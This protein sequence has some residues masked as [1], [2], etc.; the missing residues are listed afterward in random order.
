MS[1]LIFKYPLDFTGQN[2]TNRIFEEIHSLQGSGNRA[3]IPKFGAFYTASLI[4]TDTVS[5]KQL[6]A[7]DQYVPILYWDEPSEKSGLEVCAGV[8]ITD[9]TVSNSVVITYQCVGGLYANITGI[10]S[11]LINTLDIDNRPVSWGDLLDVPNAF[12]PVAHLHALGDIYGFEYIVDKLEGIRHAI[13]T[14]DEASHVEILAYINQRADAM[15]QAV[16]HV[17]ET[18]GGHVQD[19]DNPH[20]T[21]KGH[22]GL[23][24]V[25]NFPTA[26]VEIA[27]LGESNAHF[28]TPLLV[29]QAIDALTNYSDWDVVAGDWGYMRHRTSGLTVQWGSTGPLKHGEAG[30]C[31]FRVPFD[32]RPWTVVPGNLTVS[33][34][35]SNISTQDNDVFNE[36]YCSVVN[37]SITAE[38]LIMAARRLGGTQ[39]DWTVGTWMAVGITTDP[40]L[41]PDS[42]RYMFLGTDNIGLGGDI[43]ITNVGGFAIDPNTWTIDLFSQDDTVFE[44]T[45]NG[46]EAIRGTVV[47]FVVSVA[48]GTAQ[49]PIVASN[50]A[51]LIAVSPIPGQFAY[52]VMFTMPGNDVEI[53]IGDAR[54]RYPWS[55]ELYE[56]DDTTFEVIPMSGE[57]PHGSTVTFR[58]NT[59]FGT[60]REPN[61]QSSNATNIVV[62]EVGDGVLAH[63]VSFTMPSAPTTIIV[64]D[65]PAPAFTLNRPTLTLSNI[66]EDRLSWLVGNIA[67]TNPIQTYQVQLHRTNSS[68]TIIYET[69]T[70]TDTNIGQWLNLNNNTTYYF[71][72]VFT[73]TDIYGQT[74]TSQE[75]I[76]RQAT[77]A[78]PTPPATLFLEEFDI[79]NVTGYLIKV[80]S[81]MAPPNTYRIVLH[82]A[83]YVRISATGYDISVH[84]VLITG[85]D[86]YGLANTY[87]PLATA[88]NGYTQ[89][90]NNTASYYAIL[91]EGVFADVDDARAWAS[92]RSFGARTLS[93]RVVHST[94]GVVHTFPSKG[95]REITT[96][97][98]PPTGLPIE[99]EDPGTG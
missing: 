13:L 67:G 8:V 59:E 62:T 65:L 80:P 49:E 45:P 88:I 54:D 29:A 34:A 98:Y 55:I 76:I 12:P 25:D 3:I 16:N 47:T 20:G 46:G 9:T 56:Q 5:N 90:I 52:E 1:G 94:N 4:V 91:D 53:I 95:T 92:N 24:N 33:G 41:S 28:M 27:R 81:H 17:V 78:S 7:G 89:D 61:V 73:A 93:V 70:G 21:N 63:D 97:Y 35:E 77:T 58:V 99:P 87:T 51:G 22:V 75:S 10:I 11:D 19:M 60:F 82:A 74:A 23:G 85:S 43:D 96:P 36:I 26:S 44:V 84:R 48:Q 37:R 6:I 57:A 14:G 31:G 69:S 83:T 39:D 66:G 68:G 40:T 50:N 79:F 30:Q 32:A 72:A 64:G 18:F 15:Q 42:A 2:T 86:N 71:M 38:S